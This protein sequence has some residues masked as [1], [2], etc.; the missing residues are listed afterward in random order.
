MRWGMSNRFQRTYVHK[1]CQHI[2]VDVR[3]KAANTERDALK[4][5]PADIIETISRPYL[6]WGVMD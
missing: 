1:E 5:E 2:K 6:A 4:E 3:F